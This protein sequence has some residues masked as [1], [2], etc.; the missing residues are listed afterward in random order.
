MESG[1][2][3]S[4]V[5][6]E[7]DVKELKSGTR[8]D[9]A[10]TTTMNTSTIAVGDE[11]FAKITHDYE[12]DGAVVIPKGTLIHGICQDQGGPG[13]MGRNGYL[14]TKFDY[15]ITP[16][17]REIPIEGKYSNKEGALKNAAKMVARGAGYSLAGGVIGALTVVKYGGLAAVAATEG[18]ALA[19]GAAVGGAVGLGA[20]V[21][22]K[23]KAQLITPG[24]KLTIKLAEPI[25]LPSMTLPDPSEH[26]TLPSGMDVNVL[27]MHVGKDPFGE[28][29]EL[30][31]TVD[32]QNRTPHTFTT[33]DI[34]LKDEHGSVFY[35][36]PFGDTGLWFTTL[37]P[38]SRMVGYLS[39]SVD[40]PRLDHILLFYKRYTRET[41]GQVALVDTMLADAKTAK[42]R[43]K[44]AAAKIH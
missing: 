17:G 2:V 11:F 16:D 8:L 15:L 29:T 25:N 42:R 37:K 23:G 22:G 36:S 10:L 41:L 27:A 4:P 32:I 13:R 33:F 24:D 38:N 26:N 35:P 7:D 34:A 21:L 14:T 30:T 6:N 19:G 39:F 20:A 9:M 5:V 44:E 40:N 3:D 18:Y 31:L 12:V 43:L 1:G 28:L